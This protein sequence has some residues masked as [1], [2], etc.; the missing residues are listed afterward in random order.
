[1]SF[2]DLMDR[3]NNGEVCIVESIADYSPIEFINR[4][5]QHFQHLT[6][7]NDYDQAGVCWIY[8][9]QIRLQREYNP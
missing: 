3:V 4:N 7:E 9:K 5:Y 2:K 1:M 8:D 6:I